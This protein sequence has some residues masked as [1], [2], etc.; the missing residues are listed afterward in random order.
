[1]EVF[2]NQSDTVTVVIPNS[3][4]DTPLTGVVPISWQ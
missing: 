2:Q 1:M 4:D 3:A